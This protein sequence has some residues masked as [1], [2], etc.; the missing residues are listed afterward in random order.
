MDSGISIII[1]LYDANTDTNKIKNTIESALNQKKELLSEILICADVV[2]E[3]VKSLLSE[4]EKKEKVKVLY[5][6]ERRGRGGALNI[7]LIKSFGGETKEND[8]ICF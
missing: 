7:G 8:W 2:S 1:G 6:S 3:K 5:T 4:Y